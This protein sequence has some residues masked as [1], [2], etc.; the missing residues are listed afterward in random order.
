MRH[1]ER[2]VPGMPVPAKVKLTDPDRPYE[3]QILCGIDGAAAWRRWGTYKLHGEARHEM[4]LA[5]RAHPKQ[6]F[7][8]HDRR[9]T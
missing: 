4:V 6:L 3:I 9:R 2:E 5:E 8:V 7:R 1:D